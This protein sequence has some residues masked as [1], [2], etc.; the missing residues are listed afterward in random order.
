[1]NLIYV[2]H[3]IEEILPSITHVLLLKNGR[4]FAQGKKEDVLTD[5]MLSRAL[6]C[7]LT[8]QQNDG[9]FWLTGCRPR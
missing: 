1:M 8:V 2:T 9:R 6:D 7:R 4:I 5:A 3:H